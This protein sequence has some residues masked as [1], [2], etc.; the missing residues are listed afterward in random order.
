MEKV[1]L[2]VGAVREVDKRTVDSRRPVVFEAE[3][4]G[5]FTTLTGND[6]TRG[7]DQALYKT[8]DGRLVVY[9]KDWSL[10]QGEATSY[11]LAEVTNDDLGVGGEYEALGRECG[12]GRPLTLDEALVGV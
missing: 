8:G 6:G 4:V 2:Q 3:K 9:T 5:T 7:F 1:E 10:W 11:S 12:Y